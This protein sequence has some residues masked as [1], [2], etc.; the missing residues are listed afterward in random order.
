MRPEH[1]ECP[2]PVCAQFRHSQDV[3]GVLLLAVGVIVALVGLVWLAGQVA[4]GLVGGGWPEVPLA[5]LPGILARLPKHLAD[6]ARAW[7]ATV[8]GRLPGPT[9]MYA[10]LALLLAVPVL[11]GTLAVWVRRRRTTGPWQ[12]TPRRDRPHHDPGRH[13]SALS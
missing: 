7:P 3:D 13:R 2:C 12:T 8:R 10:A 4:G 6:P 9:G 5:E 1:P 11:L